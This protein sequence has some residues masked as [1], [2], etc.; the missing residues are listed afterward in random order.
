MDVPLPCQ[1]QPT[2][3][4]NREHTGDIRTTPEL[5]KRSYQAW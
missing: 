3:R 1:K 4:Y 5:P 2:M